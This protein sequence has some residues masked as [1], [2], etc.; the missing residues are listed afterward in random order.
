[1]TV[2]THPVAAV[3]G[4]TLLVSLAGCG[5]STPPP[6]PLGAKS[7]SVSPS[8]VQP[9]NDATP[10][11]PSSPGND[12]LSAARTFASVFFSPD[13]RSMD[14]YI[15]GVETSSTGSFRSDFDGKQTQLRSV[16]TSARSIASGLVL[17]AGI[18]D[19]TPTTATALLAVDQS[20]Q[21]TTTRGKDVTQ[22]YRIGERLRLVD[23]RWLVESLDP[24]DGSYGAGCPD[25]TT[26]PARSALLAASCSSIAKLFSYD[27]RHIDDDIATQHALS[28]GALQ[29][30]IDQQTG[31]ALRKVAVEEK[32]TVQAVT[33]TA[34]I[35]SFDGDHATVLLFVNQAVQSNKL[36]APRLDRN[37]VEATM[38][39]VHGQWLVSEVKAL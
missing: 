12:A 11:P 35:E 20:V 38:E 15:T 31:P 39:L 28:T 29:N 34:A 33:S 16:V 4:L 21:N 18:R 27:Y 32:A 8:S 13:Y 10:A 23:G 2:R 24:V 25:G 6:H 37:R 26:T 14:G 7:P 30:E 3:A 36:P 9:S 1:V 17:A 5:S 19:V 22:H